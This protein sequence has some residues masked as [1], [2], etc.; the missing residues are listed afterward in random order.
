MDDT[1][2]TIDSAPVTTAETTTAAPATVETSHAATT[3]Q[4][5]TDVRSLAKWMAANESAA[6]DPTDASAKTDAATTAPADAKDPTGATHPTTEK[7]GPIPFEVHDKALQNARTKSADEATAKTREQFAPLE[8]AVQSW[9]PIAQ[10]MTAD[11]VGFVRDYIAEVAASNPAIAAQMRSEAGRMLA[12]GRSAAVD[13][14]PPP[15]VQIVDEHG[16]VTGT[17]YSAKALAER[18]AWNERRLLAKVNGELAPIKAERAQQLA[19][20]QAAEFKAAT[21]AKVDEVM[22]ELLDILDGDDSLGPAVEQ[23]MT[24]NPSWSAHKAALEVRK[25]HIVPRLEG[26][27]QQKVVD[28]FHKKAA[29]NTA[30]GTGTT[31]AP[32]RLKTRGDIA[33]FLESHAG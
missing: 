13:A 2:T 15:D 12:G 7:K 21:D 23:L 18:D 19:D 3:S 6:A 28:T 24:A 4:R 25:T 26:K 16:R 14:E 9:Q 31:A 1:T 8:R 20:A 27:A 10:R 29:G 32:T 11:P 17:T 33:K 30:N 22:A 5:P